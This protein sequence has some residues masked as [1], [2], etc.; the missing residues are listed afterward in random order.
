MAMKEVSSL[1]GKGR[2]LIPSGMRDA[3]NITE[4]EKIVLELDLAGRAIRIEPAYERKLLVIHIVLG[5]RPGALASA[6]TVL[7]DLGVDL[8]AT[9]SHSTRRGEAA[10]WEVEC[11]PAKA[12]VHRIK[13]GL[14]KVGARIASAKWE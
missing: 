13:E 12:S 1:D 3:L 4:G 6:A 8:V 7:A 10:V 2:V 14:A 9:R 5:D 11:N